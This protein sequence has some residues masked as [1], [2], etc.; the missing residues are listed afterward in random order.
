M[1]K[2]DS[3]K[4]QARAGTSRSR[5]SAARVDAAHQT[6]T[7]SAQGVASV[8]ALL[9]VAAEQSKPAELP[10][11]PLASL[12]GAQLVDYLERRHRDLNRREALLNSQSAEVQT[13]MRAARLWF[14]ERSEELERREAAL[15]EREAALH[16]R[17]A[18]TA[19]AQAEELSIGPAGNELIELAAELDARAHDLE[20]RER[21]LAERETLAENWPAA[22]GAGSPNPAGWQK[23]LRAIEQAERTLQQV[24]GEWEAAQRSLADE[25][26]AFEEQIRSRRVELAEQELKQQNQVQEAR[27]QLERRRLELEQRG[28]ALHHLRDRI[29]AV[30]RESLEVRAATEEL[31]SQL[32]GRVQP[33]WLAGAWGDSRRRLADQFR[34]ARQELIERQQELATTAPR[35]E[36]QLAEIEQRR[37][38]L[39]TWW[40]RRQAELTALADDLHQRRRELDQREMQ[41]RQAVDAWWSQRTGSQREL[42]AILAE[43]RQVA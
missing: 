30:H 27:S 19:G 18:R 17:E 24:Q 12:H 43:L 21:E 10:D 5:V 34:L 13:D 4:S 42:R 20:R 38:E 6:A 14:S 39:Q 11:E 32:V 16:A 15:N 29:E 8:P 31:W 35:L 28:D 23:R 33:D 22:R 2:S 36:A 41:H 3:K 7:E 25:R 40:L 9:S 37:G 1:R 26:L